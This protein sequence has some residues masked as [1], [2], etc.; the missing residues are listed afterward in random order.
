MIGYLNRSVDCVLGL[1]L[2]ILRVVFGRRKWRIVARRASE[3]KYINICSPNSRKTF[4]AIQKCISS[5]MSAVISVK[6]SLKKTYEKFSMGPIIL[7]FKAFVC[8][9]K[10]NSKKCG[11]MK[12]FDNEKR[13]TKIR[14]YN[15]KVTD[16]FYLNIIKYKPIC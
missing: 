10:T 9:I 14:N 6:I 4:Q 12:N 11:I 2:S 13:I 8:F 5:S 16:L 15:E 3:T 7:T 1:R